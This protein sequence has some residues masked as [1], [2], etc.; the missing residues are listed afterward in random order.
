MLFSPAVFKAQGRWD[1]WVLATLDTED[2]TQPQG[3]EK[4]EAHHDR[5]RTVYRNVNLPEPGLLPGHPTRHGRYP[6]A[7]VRFAV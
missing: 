6:C 4:A 2:I 3:K 5:E 1:S 7:Q